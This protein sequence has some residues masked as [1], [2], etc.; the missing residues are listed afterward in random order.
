LARAFVAARVD[1]LVY[2]DSVQVHGDS[3]RWLVGFQRRALMAP[4]HLTVEIMRASGA[5]RFFGD[6]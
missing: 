4:T 3:V 6:E 5:A 1:T 2:P